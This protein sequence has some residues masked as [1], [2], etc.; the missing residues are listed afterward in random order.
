MFY[1][2]S[3]STVISGRRRRRIGGGGGEGKGGG[4]GGGKGGGGGGRGEGSVLGYT[5]AEN[6]VFSNFIQDTK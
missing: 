3:I 1:A 4:G 2:Q 5:D 6:K